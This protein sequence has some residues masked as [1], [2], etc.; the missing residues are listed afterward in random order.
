MALLGGG[1]VQLWLCT[2]ARLWLC[3][4]IGAKFTWLWVCSVV[5]LPGC[6]YARLWRC[7]AVAVALLGFGPPQLWL[8][9]LMFCPAVALLFGFRQSVCTHYLQ[10]IQ[11]RT[12][13]QFICLFIY[14]PMCVLLVLTLALRI[15]KIYSLV[16][17]NLSSVV[18]A[19]CLQHLAAP[20]VR[21]IGSVQ[22]CSLNLGSICLFK[23]SDLNLQTALIQA[24]LHLQA[25]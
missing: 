11:A 19:S 6:G 21:K 22:Q 12:T 1:C 24:V 7:S 25:A 5:A 2:C 15:A 14:F 23:P 10:A 13:S 17:E 16:V 9:R 4:A 8:Y 18:H 3:S 20:G